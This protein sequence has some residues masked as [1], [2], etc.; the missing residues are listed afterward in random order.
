MLSA[1]KALLYKIIDGIFIFHQSLTGHRFYNYQLVFAR[2]IVESVLL[3]DGSTITG[4]WSRQSGKTTAVAE[5]IITLTIILPVL[6]RA[7][8]PYKVDP[9]TG[10]ELDER[11]VRVP[12]LMPFVEGLRVGIFAPIEHQ[13]RISYNKMR[14]IAHSNR[15]KDILEDEEI[16]TTID[17]SRGDTLSLSNNSVI[18]ART[19]S[20]NSK[21]EGETFHII[22]IDEAQDV[23]RFKVDKE[24]EPMRAATN[25]T[26][27]K[28]GTANLSRG[29]FHTDIEQNIAKHKLGLAPRN[30]FQFDYTI[31]IAERRVMYEKTKDRSHL[32]YE[33]YVERQKQRLGGEKSLA[34]KLNFLLLWQEANQSAI[35][36]RALLT[37][38]DLTYELNS[39]KQ[40]DLNAPHR[41]LRVGGLDI[42]KVNDSTV[43]T[44]MEYDELNPI[45]FRDRVS[46][47]IINFFKKR[48]AG[49][50]SLQGN[51][52]DTPGVSYG[53]Y[54][55]VV[56]FFRHWEVD[57]VVVDATSMGNPIVERLQTLAPEIEWV[58]FK[59]N[60]ITKGDLYR[61]YCD[62]WEANRILVAS[63]GN[64]KDMHEW[65]AF[66]EEHRNLE[67]TVR[68]NY[69][70]YHAPKPSSTRQ[71]SGEEE[72]HDDFPDSGALAAWGVK[73]SI[74][75]E[76]HVDSPGSHT[77]TNQVPS[78]YASAMSR[79]AGQNNRYRRRW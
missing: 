55:E 74:A 66:Y 70:E 4:L 11:D 68:G 42:G 3:N 16:N 34:F 8:N 58:P 1:E 65:Q 12:M 25:G 23:D 56:K 35:S 37:S 54:T 75:Q 47:E 64:S 76:V 19:A 7:M 59:F 52:E 39:K 2:R 38:E 13:A 30:H 31:V 20:P 6:A 24:I 26:M 45:Q 5:L 61:H 67:K 33:K 40:H 49:L 15:A 17:I 44:V 51:F 63:A 32:S 28:I 41:W 9:E 77:H 10:V 50:L 72:Y 73:T 62:E 18:W 48:V 53:Q 57:R 79:M 69:V 43:G 78:L 36:A 60:M 71:A 29:G 22:L 46:G 27:V 14:K 21:V